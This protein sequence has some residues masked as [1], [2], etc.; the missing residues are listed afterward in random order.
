MFTEICLIIAQDD[1]NMTV[2][3][4]A[5]GGSDV[6][7][8]PKFIYEY[9]LKIYNSINS[10]YQCMLSYPHYNNIMQSWDQ[11]VVWRNVSS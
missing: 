11:I 7:V 2:C 5:V 1:Q 4:H 3:A 8:H 9:E 10:L 6:H